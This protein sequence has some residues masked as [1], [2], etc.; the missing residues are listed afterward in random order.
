VAGLASIFGVLAAAR[1]TAWGSLADSKT[2][3]FSSEQQQRKSNENMKRSLFIQY[4]SGLMLGVAFFGTAANAEFTT[5]HSVIAEI[6][7][8]SEFGIACA[9]G[10]ARPINAAGIT[11]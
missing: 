1:K 11:A 2:R 8:P 9:V 7:S 5:V 4:C 6:L 3:S 10:A